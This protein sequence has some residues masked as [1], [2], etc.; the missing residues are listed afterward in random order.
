MCE[1][2]Q[3]DI[4]ENYL[5]TLIEPNMRKNIEKYKVN[6]RHIGTQLKNIYI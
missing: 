3:T 5:K 1:K 6:S 2:H 4:T